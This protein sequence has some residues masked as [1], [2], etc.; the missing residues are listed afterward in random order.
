MSQ[1][2][3]LVSAPKSARYWCPYLFI[4]ILH[5]VLPLLPV[6]IGLW[7]FVRS[8]DVTVLAFDAPSQLHALPLNS[9]SE[10]A[11]LSWHP[12]NPGQLAVVVSMIVVFF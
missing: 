2:L 1:I 12:D 7:C 3:R 9:R 11:G 8:R 5:I 10:P 6:V 4:S